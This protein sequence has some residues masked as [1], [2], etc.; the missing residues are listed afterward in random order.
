MKTLMSVLFKVISLIAALAG[1][2]FL[3]TILFDTKLSLASP[4]FISP[5]NLSNSAGSSTNPWIAT[6]GIGEDIYA[7]WEEN[8][9]IFLRCS[10][11]GGVTF[12]SPLQLSLGEGTNSTPRIAVSQ[13]KTDDMDSE[14]VAVVWVRGGMEVVFRG[15]FWDTCNEYQYF[16]YPTTISNTMDPS[17]TGVALS[18]SQVI[19]VDGDNIYVSWVEYFP[20]PVTV[21]NGDI[22]FTRSTDGGGNSF[23]TPVNI[24]NTLSSGSLGNPSLAHQ[25]REIVVVWD[26]LVDGNNSEIFHVRSLDGGATFTQAANLSN[27]AALPYDYIAGN[28]NVV[29]SGDHVY[30]TWTEEG[31]GSVLVHSVDGGTTFG[32]PVLV[33]ATRIQSS[34]RHV[35][36]SGLNNDFLTN[37]LVLSESFDYGSTFTPPQTMVSTV[38][39]WP[40]MAMVTARVYLAD[41]TH[42]IYL[43][44][45]GGPGSTTQVM[46]IRNSGVDTDGD[47]LFDVDETNYYNT[48]PAKQDTDEDTLSDGAEV[49]VYG[50]DPLNADT[51][52][53]GSAD[54]MEAPGLTNPFYPGDDDPDLDRLSTD[55]E[56]VLGTNPYLPD[57]NGN[58]TQD[59][60][61]DADGDGYAN[62]KEFRAGSNPLDAASIPSPFLQYR[63]DGEGSGDVFGCLVEGTCDLSGDG[64]PDT[65]VGAF[66]ADPNGL[67]D[68][69]RVYVFSGNDG[70]L[71]YTLDGENAYDKFGIVVE[72]VGD[73]NGDGRCDLIVGAPGWGTGVGMAYLYSG[74]DGTLLRKWTGGYS[75]RNSVSGIGDIDGD[76]VPDLVVG[77]PWNSWYSGS[78]MAYVYSGTTGVLLYTFQGS[79]YS[80]IGSTIS[81]FGQSV[82]GVGDVNG[83]GTPDILVAAPDT[84]FGGSWGVGSVFVFSGADGSL[85]W[86]FNGENDGDRFGGFWFHG[87][88]SA[89]DVNGDGRED[90]LIGATGADPNG[91]DRAGSAYVYSGATGNLLYRLDGDVEGG[92]FGFWVSPVGD[93]DNDWKGDFIIGAPAGGPGRPS[94]LPGSAYL[95]SGATG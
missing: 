61:E 80:N 9:E 34:G 56:G 73:V 38:E 43:D 53:G 15:A 69:G 83:D 44:D 86:R 26:D 31:A 33:A 35:V 94:L 32:S 12:T 25:E 4:P 66:D 90:I 77:E 18:E 2:F 85:L 50:T 10:P 19:G 51:D 20:D 89:G 8:G 36:V 92:R 14:T 82:S 55:Q 11:D 22:F 64:E 49:K 52:G 67:E 81:G 62:W 70:K 28:P 39:G 68:S 24:S 27:T 58:G 59:G 54:G 72:G 17:V 45:P 5:I 65:V 42:M 21:T 93:T 48:D 88:S 95:Y 41:T 29:M 1:A 16:N 91:L 60:N 6:D 76:S 63:F 57:T 13:N 40:V 71:L 23:S 84:Y 78:G 46:Y 30:V 79:D 74:A 47:G 3:S 75:F 37:D 87:V 7:V